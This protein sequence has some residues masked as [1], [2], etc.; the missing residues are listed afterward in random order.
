MRNYLIS[1]ALVAFFV[2]GCGEEKVVESYDYAEID[3][4]VVDFKMTESPLGFT[5]CTIKVTRKGIT[6]IPFLPITY[7]DEGCDQD[8][9]T[10]ID[11]VSIKTE[12]V[13]REINLSQLSSKDAKKINDKYRFY[14]LEIKKLQKKDLLQ[15]M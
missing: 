4:A 5:T 12:N 2:S 6:D 14:Y 10:L 1:I 7:I 9:D 15:R 3:N 11:Q 13:D 8:V